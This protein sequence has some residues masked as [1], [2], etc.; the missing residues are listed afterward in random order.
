MS[1]RHDVLENLARQFGTPCFV[2][3]LDDVGAR[4]DA[5][6]EAFGGRFEVSYAVKSNPNPAIVEWM[7][8]KV[9]A[10]DISSG[11]EL[12]R[13]LAA[14]WNGDRISFTG[15]GKRAWELSDSL[16]PRGSPSS[17]VESLREAE[18]LDALAG[19]QGVSSRCCSASRR[20]RCRAASASTWPASRRS[21]A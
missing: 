9:P 19:R 5:I 18:D 14:G 2:Y 17:C 10:L 7:K 1:A 12:H 13:A 4:L 15:P 11:G 8:D 3:F 6:R 20:R 21:S 16:S